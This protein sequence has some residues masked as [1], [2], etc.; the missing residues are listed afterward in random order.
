MKPPRE[1]F[2]IGMYAFTCG[3][4]LV[5]YPGTSELKISGTISDEFGNKVSGAVVAIIASDYAGMERLIAYSKGRSNING[6]YDVELHHR[7]RHRLV[8]S[9]QLERRRPSLNCAA[10]A[11]GTAVSYFRCDQP[12][13]VVLFKPITFAEIK[14]ADPQTLSKRGQ[15]TSTS[16]VHLDALLSECRLTASSNPS[17]EH[18]L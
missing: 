6:E 4:S 14:A 5:G 10:C 18:K 9:P 8:L 11:P 12:S 7:S 1:W 17:E 3:C 13:E 15:W 2:L 16:S